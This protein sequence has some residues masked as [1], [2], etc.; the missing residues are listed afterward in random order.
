M[1]LPPLVLAGC[2][3]G[4]SGGSRPVRGSDLTIYSSLPMHGVGAGAARA[5]LAGQRLALGHAAGRVGRYRVRLVPLDAA[6]P[7]GG[8]WDPG[9]TSA[10]ASRATDDPTAIAYLGELGYGASAV[11]VPITNS[12][13]LL[14]LS[15]GDGLAS[16]TRTP[17]GE[18]QR[19]GPIRYYPRAGRTFLRLVPDD[20][21]VAAALLDLDESERARRIAVL[22]DDGNYGEELG[23][24]TVALAARRGKVVVG[25]DDFNGNPSS[26]SGLA[27]KIAERRPDA[28]VHAGVVAPGTPSLLEALERAL[29]GVP[30][31]GSGG[32]SP[33]APQSPASPGRRV[34]V[35]SPFRASTSYPARGRRL[36]RALPASARRPEALYGYESMRLVLDA[37]R[38]REAEGKRPTRAGVVRAALAPRRRRGAIGDYRI[39]RSGDV[40]A[41][42]FAEYRPRAGRLVFE[43]LVR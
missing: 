10:N 1:L 6:R 22:T 12:A 14:E 42:G 40:S 35:L 39:E 11:S 18:L 32:L 16:L 25:D 29:P 7:G 2:L 8:P 28:I 20:V 4:S 36:L 43:R 26:V 34:V 37:I 23:R 31:V 5:V 13:G 17:P 15:P 30:V 27:R 21:R 19:G 9:R 24:T 41:P 3:G 38:A 33:D